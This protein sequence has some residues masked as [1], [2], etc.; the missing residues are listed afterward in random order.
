MLQELDLR[1]N[2]VTKNETDYQL[3]VVHMLVNLRRLGKHV[4]IPELLSVPFCMTTEIALFAC[5][6]MLCMLIEPAFMLIEPVNITLRLYLF[7]VGHL[8]VS[9]PLHPRVTQISA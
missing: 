8:T 3:F 5:T 4:Y 6:C 7:L 1:L 2:P 9:L